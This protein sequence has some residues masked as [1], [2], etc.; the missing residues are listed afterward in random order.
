MKSFAKN[1]LP[2]M[3]NNPI[4]RDLIFILLA[5]LVVAVSLV[6]VSIIF[7]HQL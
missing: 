4:N 1:F 6:T 7:L 2:E 3:M 5:G